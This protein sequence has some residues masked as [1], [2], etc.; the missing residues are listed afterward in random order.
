MNREEKSNIINA[1]IKQ[2]EALKYENEL[3]LKM[4]L[5]Y[6]ET[7]SIIN[8]LKENISKQLICLNIL[9]NEL[10]CIEREV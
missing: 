8:D 9:N 6:G 5:A 2:I 1:K 3:V 4:K 7:E 10:E